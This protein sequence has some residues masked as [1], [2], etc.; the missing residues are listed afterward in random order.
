MKSSNK[1]TPEEIIT[2]QVKDR[3]MGREPGC[4]VGWCKTRQ[5]KYSRKLTSKDWPAIKEGL[6][7]ICGYPWKMAQSVETI[8]GT[9]KEN[10]IKGHN[11]IIRI[12]N[13]YRQ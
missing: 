2:K 6:C 10:N 12:L 4:R 5:E 7:P 1:P 9:L 11:Q 3:L 13:L 8:Q